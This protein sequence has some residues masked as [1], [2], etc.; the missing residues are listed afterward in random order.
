MTGVPLI[1][2]G[3]VGLA[4]AFGRFLYPLFRLLF[5][6]ATINKQAVLISMLQGPQGWQTGQ[7]RCPSRGHR[8]LTSTLLLAARVRYRM[9]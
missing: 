2:A 1:L 8:E 6:H 7:S 3:S 9:R 4:G 5:P